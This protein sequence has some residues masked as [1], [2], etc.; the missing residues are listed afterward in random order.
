MLIHVFFTEYFN[1]YLSLLDFFSCQYKHEE[2][3]LK[4]CHYE[5]YFAEILLSDYAKHPA[6]IDLNFEVVN[7]ICKL[8]SQ[9]I[10]FTCSA[11]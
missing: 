3:G 4:K 1:R 2:K 11:F 8:Q 5:S 6:V 10:V 7:N 9:E